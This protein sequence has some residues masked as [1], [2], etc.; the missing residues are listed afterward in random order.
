MLKASYPSGLGALVLAGLNRISKSITL[1]TSY[2]LSLLGRGVT[3]LDIF[4]KSSSPDL[5]LN[6]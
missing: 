6:S 4:L 1:D 5:F 2:Q 3:A